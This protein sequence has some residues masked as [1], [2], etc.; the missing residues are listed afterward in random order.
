MSVK[1][2]EVNPLEFQQKNLTQ[3]LQH[4]HHWEEEISI[5]FG[6]LQSFP[7]IKY[8]LIKTILSFPVGNEHAV[9]LLATQVGNRKVIHLSFD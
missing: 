4:S 8:K 1:E 7:V 2:K 5:P 9:F 6:L 3:L